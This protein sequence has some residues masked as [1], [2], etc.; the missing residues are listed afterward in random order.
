MRSKNNIIKSSLVVRLS[1]CFFLLGQ[2]ILHI[3]RGKIHYRKTM[4]YMFKVGPE[5]LISVLIINSFYGIILTIYVGQAVV[6]YGAAAELGQPF[7]FAFWRLV[8]VFAAMIILGKI[9]TAFT[10]EIG[11]MKVTE[12]IDALYILRT[13]PINFLVVP[14]VIACAVMLPILAMFGLLAGTISA[15][16]AAQIIYQVNP[17]TF[18]DS[19]RYAIALSD[20][21]AILLKGCVFGISMSVIGCGWGLTTIRGSKEV[22]ES[23]TEAILV[24]SMALF[25]G[26]FVISIAMLANPITLIT[27]I[28]FN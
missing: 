13:C 15:V 12:Q 27:N 1:F 11:M 20:L 16:F 23:T 28:I 7:A 17:Y 4:E 18:L 14:K 8:P 9:T 5:S 10:V 26:D 21:M 2:V 24:A 3:L 25:L 6:K 22:G 19:V